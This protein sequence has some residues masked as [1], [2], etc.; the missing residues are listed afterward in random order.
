[1]KKYESLY[2]GIAKDIITPSMSMP[3][4]G[5]AT[6]F[7]A[8]F[9]DIHD[10]L[11]VRALV[12][13]D[14]DGE[15][16][17]LV[18][19]DL[20]FH[21]DSLADTLREYIVKKYGIPGRNLHVNYTHTH[22]GPAVKGYDF[23]WYTN[24][25]EE[26][27]IGRTKSA[28][29]RALLCMRKGTL[30]YAS[31]AGEWNISRRLSVDGEIMLRPNPDGECDKNLY[32]LKF[33]DENGKM[34]ALAL[35][36]AC[37]PSNL[38]CYSVL[39]SEY[40]GRLCQRIEGEFYGTTAIFFQGFGADAK[41]R[42]GATKTQKFTGISYDDCDEVAQAMLQRIKIQ[43]V[44]GEW[45]LVPVKLGSDVFCVNLPLEVLPREHYLQH[46][47]DFTVDA[48]ERFVPVPGKPDSIEENVNNFWLAHSDYILDNYDSLSNELTLN[49]GV[50]RI[51]PDFYVFS[52]G[53][54]PGC[55]IAAVLQE[56]FPDKKIICLGYNNAIAYIPSDKMI[57][58]GGYEAG[59]RSIEEY[60]LKG[61][62]KPGVNNIFVSGYSDA[63]SRIENK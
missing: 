34:R 25:Y 13:R 27:L 30:K 2:F 7:G 18:S 16:V 29:D 24:E 46:R 41:L 8:E 61:S 9:T 32:M 17:I 11:F 50:I 49:C 38:S 53:G 60:C 37:H 42:I 5:F 47:R 4:I 63:I 20:L 55:N 12:L 62:I 45:K 26:F 52:M 31:V 59:G 14:E 28:I 39:S 40:P 10:D 35:N 51:N 56:G 48:S 23:V 44:S 58:E 33:E 1:M 43:L 22:F 6:M 54:E 57:S 19:Y 15:T 21:D 36:F 3:M